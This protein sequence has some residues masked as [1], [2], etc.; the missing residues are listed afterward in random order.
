MKLGNLTVNE[1][2]QETSGASVK[3]IS[4]SLKN[5]NNFLQFVYKIYM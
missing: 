1:G 5:K 3:R 4:T 2:T